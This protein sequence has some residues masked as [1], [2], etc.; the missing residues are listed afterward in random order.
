MRLHVGNMVDKLEAQLLLIEL[1]EPVDGYMARPRSLW[2][3]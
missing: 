1:R 3:H 2:G